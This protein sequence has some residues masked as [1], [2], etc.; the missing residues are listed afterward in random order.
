[1][2]DSDLQARIQALAEGLAEYKSTVADAAALL[3]HR[4]SEPIDLRDALGQIERL[5][6]GHDLDRS[7][8][9]GLAEAIRK[10]A[11]RAAI[12]CETGASCDE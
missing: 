2:S 1:M 11:A 12:K 3:G 8:L 6:A 5:V 10:L 4:G 7:D 9:T